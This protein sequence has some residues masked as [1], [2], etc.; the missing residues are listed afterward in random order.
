MKL[1]VKHLSCQVDHKT[2]VQDLSFSLEAGQLVGL[3]GPNGAGK[4]SLLK[5]LAG[6]YPCQQGQ[7]LV[8]G[9]DV[10]NLS[11]KAFAQ[12]VAYMQQDPPISFSYRVEALVMTARTPYL[13]WWQQESKADKAI[14]TQ[15]MK[16]TGVYDLRHRTIDSLSGGERQR[17]F[18][19]KA[20][21]QEASCLLLD[22]PAAALDLMHAEGLFRLVRKQCQEGHSALVVVHDLELAAKYC[23]RLILLSEGRLV[24]DGAPLEVLTPEHLRE[25]YGM[26]ADVYPDA[27]YGHC[28]IYLLEEDEADAK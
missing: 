27:K 19:A 17:V 13:A 16:E 8:D 14:A 10:G 28:R 18:L 1:D 22:E 23:S 9:V 15:A 2:L 6:I 11:R 25:A 5:T 24:A 26:E 4:S 21:A 12:Q 3:I 7:I 20:L